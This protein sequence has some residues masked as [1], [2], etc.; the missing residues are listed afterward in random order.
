MNPA[1]LALL[2]AG[3]LPPALPPARPISAHLRR[4]TVLYDAPGG[5]RLGRV[6]RRTEFGSRTVLSIADRRRGWLGVR[7]PMVAN[8]RI[9]WIRS[10]VATIRTQP[11]RIEVDLSQRRLIVRTDGRVSGRFK[12]AVGAA[13]TP[14]PTGVFAVTD[15]I[16]PRK[17]GPYGCCILALTGRQPK[18]PQGWGGGDRLA[19]HGTPNPASVGRA[20]SAG[21]VRASERTMRKLMKRIPQ[22]AV[23][24][25][26]A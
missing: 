18:L 8:G 26:R 21:C 12:V 19:I 7:T 23:V 4:A 5:R 20:V 6:A 22:G 3:A 16:V 25:I 15:R 13:G 14:T 1:A 24:V 2:A 11:H 9:G 10:S 17:S